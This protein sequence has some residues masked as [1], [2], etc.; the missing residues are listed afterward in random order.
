MHK[1]KLEE[2]SKKEKEA[3]ELLYKARREA[4]E[5]KDN[6]ELTLLKNEI[7][8]RKKAYEEYCKQ[9]AYYEKLLSELKDLKK[10]LGVK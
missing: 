6:K 8:D 3:G 5:D 1:R 9:T 7:D 2:L 10:K 4:E